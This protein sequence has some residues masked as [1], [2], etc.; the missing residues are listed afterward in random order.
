[1]LSPDGEDLRWQRTQL[2]A[3]LK[4]IGLEEKLNKSGN[5]EW[6]GQI[7]LNKMK[8]LGVEL[9][10]NYWHRQGEIAYEVGK[11]SPKGI[12]KLLCGTRNEIPHKQKV[13]KLKTDILYC[14]LGCTKWKSHRKHR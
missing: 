2:G 11:V 10:G 9:H 7:Q 4:E 6:N 8:Y 13:K 12:D 1:M 14:E 3:C 5:Y